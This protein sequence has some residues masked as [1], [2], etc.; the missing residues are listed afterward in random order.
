[1]KHGDPE[2]KTPLDR[3]G[4]GSVGTRAA[5]AAT[6]C[7]CVQA[8]QFLYYGFIRCD[9]SIGIHPQR[10]LKNVHIFCFYYS[11]VC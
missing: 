4:L 5:T 3:A 11:T 1:M 2:V 6:M 8:Q 7:P 9:F 10:D